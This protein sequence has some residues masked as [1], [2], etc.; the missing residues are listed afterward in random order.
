[1]MASGVRP[2]WLAA[3]AILAVAGARPAAAAG[4]LEGIPGFSHV[5]LLVLENESFATTWGSGSAATYLNG[6]RA[7]GVLADHYYATSHHSLG[8]YVALVSGQ[9]VQ[10][11]TAS[12]CAALNLYDC[13]QG[14]NAMAGG[15]NLADQ[16]ED[17][18]LSWKGYMD[19]MPGACFHANYAAA[20]PPPDP[21]QGDSTSPPAF[22]YAD[23]HNPFLYFADIIGDGSRCQAHVVPYAGLAA[24]L[25]GDTL[26][27]FSFITP[28][29][30]ND[31][32]DD[33]CA[34]GSPGGLARADLW[35]SR[36]VPPLLA[37]LQSH[38]G[39]LVITFDEASA[40]DT[41]GCCTGGPGGGPGAGGRIGLLALSAVGR[42]GQ[43]VSTPYDHASLLRTIEDS[44][45][46][47]EHLNNAATAT[48]MVELL[49]PSACP[50]GAAA[51][52][53]ADGRFAV[54]ASFA[55]A[56]GPSGAAQAVPLTSDTGYFWFFSAGNV[57]AVVKVLD[58]CAVN[59][60][61]WFF[62]GGLTD[63]Q[64]TVTV[65]DNRTHFVKAYTNPQAT[66]FQPIQDTGALPV[67]P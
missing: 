1:M 57:E 56:S 51:L 58:G 22:N 4:G 36:N 67:C 13:V 54:T 61:Y 63:V 65:T 3:L 40:A 39:L 60:S 55:T 44:L 53:L 30:C 15:R 19:A 47:A 37:Y 20:A 11:A 64:M 43:V 26:P 45:G 34:G 59:D 2:A 32:H 10:P 6:L 16:I 7:Q 24:D 28:D 52:C 42:A 27:V 18:G 31:G 5:V 48:P 38:N 33:P 17:A 66:A 29:T 41:S 46:I 49:T 14:Q 23:R 25:A 62:A 8:N 35:L 21:Y 12:D 50:P 9:P